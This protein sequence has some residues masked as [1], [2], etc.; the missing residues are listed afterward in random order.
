MNLSKYLKNQRGL[1]LIEIIIATGLL[2]AMSVGVMKVISG[3]QKGNVVSEAKLEELEIKKNIAMILADKVA[4]QK[5]FTGISIGSTLGQIKNSADNPIFEIDKVYGNNSLKIASMRTSDRNEVAADGSRVVDL[6]VGLKKNKVLTSQNIVEIKIQL[7]VIA[8]G[9]SGIISACFSATGNVLEQACDSLDGTWSGSICTLDRYVLK[10]GDSMIGTLTVPLLNA[11][12]GIESNQICSGA[13]CKTIPDLAIANLSC[14]M[15]TLQSGV[16]AAGSPICKDVNCTSDKYFA[17]L[18][19]SGN[20][21]CQKVPTGPCGA[22]NYVSSINS[23]GD[24]ICSSLP[25]DSAVLCGVGNYIQDISASGMVTCKPM[26]T[27]AGK[28]CA[29]GSYAQGFSNTGSIICQTVTTAVDCVGSWGP[30]SQA[31]GPGVRIYS[32]STA[33]SGGGTACPATNGAGQACLIESCTFDY[34]QPYI[35][36]SSGPNAGG[37]FSIAH[38][39]GCAANANGASSYGETCGPPLYCDWIFNCSGG[40][41]QSVAAFGCVGD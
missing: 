34:F 32:I 30:C 31:C 20:K 12:G 1:S 4:C 41:I 9:S 23:N 22:G 37:D 13:N 5:T 17:G 7:K 38:S 28:I 25:V 3:A 29:A 21:I 11:S 2:A 19:A 33:A 10:S 36:C 18:D 8:P 27:A 40:K 39:S 6:V 16:N 15:G 26:P 24:V 14:S 35:H